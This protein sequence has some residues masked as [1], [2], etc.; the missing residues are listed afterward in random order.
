V[1]DA[2]TLSWIELAVT[3][4]LRASGGTR[5]DLDSPAVASSR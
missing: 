1:R 4:E 2:D 5:E 3:P